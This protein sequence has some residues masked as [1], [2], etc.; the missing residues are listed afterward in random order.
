MIYLMQ[1]VDYFIFLIPPEISK[2]RKH[3]VSN[4]YIKA[5]LFFV[6][7]VKVYFWEYIFQMAPNRIII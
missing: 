3:N 4:Q 6:E 1:Y 5:L 7:I 2:Y